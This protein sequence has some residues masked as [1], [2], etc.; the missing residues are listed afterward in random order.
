MKTK[1]IIN[2][3]LYILCLF[4]VL[5][6]HLGI[7]G[8][9]LF[10]L[11]NFI[12]IFW[13]LYRVFPLFHDNV[14]ID[15]N[16]ILYLF[17]YIFIGIAPLYQFINNVTIWGGEKLK[18]N[19]YVI[20]NLVFILALLFYDFFYQYFYS[21][22]QKTKSCSGSG[23]AN[24]LKDYRTVFP[25]IIALLSTAF[26]L[27]TFKSYPQL[28][29]W[30]EL[31][32][33]DKIVFDTFG[34]TSLNLIYTIVIRPIPLLMLVFYNFIYKRFDSKCILL[35]ILALITNFPLSLPRFYVAGLYLP[36]L[37]SFFRALIKSDILI[38]TSFIIGILY[39]FPFLNQGR[40]VSK[41][42]ELSFSTSINYDMFLEGHF[43]TFQNFARVIIHNTVTWGQQ[44]LGVIFF[45]VPRSIYTDKAIGSGGYIA[46]L[47]N[48]QF[49]HISL[50]Y[51]GE[52]WINFGL[53][54]VPLFSMLLA[55]VNAKFDYKFWQ[56][57]CSY[58]FV[59]IYFVYLGL[60]FFILRGDLISCFA[61]T[62]GMF[63]SSYLCYKSFLRI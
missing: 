48:L 44:L 7:R 28:L 54:G 39:I 33:E 23:N 58:Y 25:I 8:Q 32:G 20:T 45:W 38:K 15:T 55:Y 16:A 61:Y 37:F 34:N 43:D 52:G 53:L 63:I 13:A 12:I 4:P 18:D 5:V 11:T 62:V 57:T 36:L 50:N 10:Q 21:K 60:I 56:Q 49:D 41:I 24:S 31:R 35:L 26:T 22:Q 1:P 30:R 47:Y 29:F 3:I 42:N 51:W 9:L 59:V 17:I 14:K 46:H 6:M 40:T 27:Y 19:D 2:L